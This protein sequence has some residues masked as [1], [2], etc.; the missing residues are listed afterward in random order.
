MQLAAYQ[1]FARRRQG[2]HRAA[3]AVASLLSAATTCRAQLGTTVQL[4]SFGVAVD[5]EGVVA[6][7]SFSDPGGR[8]ARARIEAARAKLAADVQQKSPLRKI[9]LVRLEQALADV[10]AAGK[11]PDETMLHL[12]GLQRVE[13]V[14]VYPEQKDLVIAGPAEGWVDD[15][16]GRAVG[17]TSGRPVVRLDDLV[18]ALRT[19]WNGPP[20][21]PFVGCTIDPTQEGLA[22]LRKFQARIP[23]SIPQA[24]QAIAAVQIGKGVEEALGLAPIRVFGVSPRTHLAGVLV[25]ADYRM[26]LIGIGREPP[27]VKMNTFIGAMTSAREGSLQ[28]WWFTPNYQCLRTSDDNLAVQLVGQGVQL[29][30]EDKLIG[31][32]GGLKSGAPPSKASRLFTESFTKKYPEIAAASPVFAQMRNAIDL[33]VVAAWV[34]HH[35]WA[36][37]IDWP[38]ATLGDEKRFAVETHPAPKQAPTV[39]NAVWKGSRLFAPAGGGVTIHPTE[40]LTRENLLADEDGAVAAERA[41]LQRPANRWW[42]D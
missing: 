21:A 37:R 4:P 17:I 34:N 14:F 20:R 19:Y 2:L 29:L 1:P 26:K 39:C 7:K 8:L 9:S 40:A 30:S 41:R 31:R 38:M 15:G 5:A 24:R 10:L 12:A 36:E 23:S 28:R 32:D 33:L 16:A 6:H 35:R 3:L 18:A 27:P 13:Y 22:N 11:K 42:W 25:E